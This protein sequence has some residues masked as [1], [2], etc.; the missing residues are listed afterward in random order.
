LLTKIEQILKN[1]RDN[2]IFFIEALLYIKTKKRQ[3]IPLK[4]NA[5]QRMIYDKIVT[6]KEKGLPVRVIVLKCR[7]T[8]VSTLSEALI[9]Q[10]TSTHSNVESMIVAHN[11]E[12]TNHLFKMSKLFYDKLTSNTYKP[13]VSSSNRKEIIFE[14]P[15]K[16]DRT[17]NPGLR[18]SIRVDTAGNLQAGRAYTLHNLHISELAFWESPDEVM[19]GLLQSVPEEPDTMIIIESTANGMGNYFYDL[20]QDAIAKKNDFIPI[21]IGWWEVAEYSRPAPAGFELFDYEHPNYDNEARIAKRFNLNNNQMH[22]RRQKIKNYFKNEL[23]KFQQEY[24]A[25]FIEAF[26]TTGSHVFDLE[27]IKDY[28]ELVKNVEPIRGEFRWLDNEDLT[29]PKDSEA[30]NAQMRNGV[31]FLPRGN[32]RWLIWQFPQDDDKYAMGCD[33]AEGL[34]D[35]NFSAAEII[36]R[37]NIAQVAEF[38]DHIKP[39]IYSDELA[40]AGHFY[41]DALIAVEAN[42]HGLTTLTHLRPI[43]PFI[44]YERDFTDKTLKPRDRM[45]WMTTRKT[46]VLMIDKLDKNMRNRDIVIMSRDLLDEMTKYVEKSDGSMGADQKATDDRIMAFAIANMIVDLVVMNIKSEYAHKYKPTNERTGR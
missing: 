12:S 19:T 21:F 30:R 11:I 23:K 29:T 1:L 28:S 36:S 9:F 3:L 44:Y 17:K 20:W 6:L 45:G 27:I 37:K 5:E 31:Q 24:P 41:N 43:Y 14:N 25:D 26:I 8:G 7:Q 32:G 46:K 42:N 15:N 2:A 38:V 10:D 34:A 18:S 4:F 39:E 35:G 16:K 13:M 22:W 33:V 40:K